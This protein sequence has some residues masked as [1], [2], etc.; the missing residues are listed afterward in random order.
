MTFAAFVVTDWYQ[1]AAVYSYA[2]DF[3]YVQAA[4]MPAATPYPAYVGL[5]LPPSSSPGPGCD[6]QVGDRVVI[7]P[8]SGRTD[9]GTGIQNI[10]HYLQNGSVAVDLSDEYRGVFVYRMCSKT[11]DHPEVRS[12][13]EM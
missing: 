10:S 6:G 13:K 9:G 11:C 8:H 5:V 3:R 1:T 7:Y 12:A 2:H 4:K